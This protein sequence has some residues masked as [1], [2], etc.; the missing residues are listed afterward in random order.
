MVILLKIETILVCKF[1]CNLIQSFSIIVYIFLLFV[2]FSAVGQKQILSGVVKNTEGIAIPYANVTVKNVKNFAIKFTQTNANGKYTVELTT[3]EMQAVLTIEASSLGYKSELQNFVK[4]RDEYNF[5]LSQEALNL[6]EIT[7]KSKPQISVNQDTLSY[8]VSSFARVEDRSIGDVIRRLPGLAVAESGQISYNG[9]IISNLFIQGDDLMDGRYGLATKAIDKNIIKSIDVIENFQPLNVL[10]NKV[11]TDD[12][13]INLIL[14]DEKSIKLA[15]QS[16]IGGGLPHQYIGAIDLMM[17]NKKLKFLNSFKAN[18]IGEDLKAELTPLGNAGLVSDIKNSKPDNILSI[19]TT[20]NPDLPKNNFYF[21]NSQL[22]NLNNLVNLKQDWQ[23]KSNFQAFIDK[24]NSAYS[25]ELAHYLNGDTVT[26]NEA[27]SVK[28]KPYGFNS[29]LSIMANKAT[30]FFNNKLSVNFNGNKTESIL[31][32]NSRNITQELNTSNINIANDLSYT[33]LIKNSKNILD[34]RWTFNYFNNPQSLTIEPGLNSDLF[35]QYVPY[36]SS[37][38]QLA[39]PTYSSNVTAAYR[40]FNSSFMQQ[41]YQFGLFNEQQKFSS[42]LYLKQITNEETAYQGDFGNDLTWHRDK[43]F[44]APNYSINRSNWRA[45]LSLPLT[46]QLITYWQDNYSVNKRIKNIF[47]SPNIN[48]TLNL[49]PEDYLSIGYNFDHNFGNI[50]S[51]FRGVV[52]GNYR[53]VYA[54]SSDLQQ[55]TISS[56]TSGFYFK[57]SIIMLF[58]SASINYDR[59]AA[60]TIS[61]SELSENIQR[62][63]FLPYPNTQTSLKFNTDFSKYFLAINTTVSLHASFSTSNFS[64]LINSQLFPFRN[65]GV[66]VSSKIDTKLFNVLTLRAE[67]SGSWLSS[68]QLSA[69]TNGLLIKNFSK[70]LYQSLN[71]GYSPLNNIFFNLTGNY[72]YGHQANTNDINYT[73]V[74]LNSRF[75]LV[76]WRTDLEFQI[77][78]LANIKKYEIFHLSANQFYVSSYELRGRMVLLKATF[79]L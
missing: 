56:V 23:L 71:V 51:V 20:G 33:P 41:N 49:N 10:K 53:S 39:I 3:S 6:K 68:S 26:Y 60:N 9:K 46:P 58:A 36:L 77:S 65:K 31:S 48:F 27:Q 8:N 57:R 1:R 44:A 61:S 70:Q 64:Q 42:D 59:V 40:V 52:L 22:L 50:A 78:N 13:A 29:S 63:V 16:S 21:N 76:K 62:R 37:R 67:S 32:F 66:F 55:Q 18:N 24:N 38:Q 72:I 12:V 4:D 79:N 25:N 43:I 7:I 28:N 73:F 17:F 2:P 74:D 75:K 54:N 14:K 19:G 34:F 35:N 15:G 45:T 5:I 47:A 11:F 30:Y 69:T